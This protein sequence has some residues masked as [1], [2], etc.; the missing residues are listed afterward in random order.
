MKTANEM[1]QLINRYLDEMPYNRQPQQLYEPIRYILSLG[2]KRIRPT[3]MM[4]AYNLYQEDPERILPQACALETYHN[5]TLLH[6]DLMDHAD[7]RRG[8][9]FKPWP[10]GCGF[11]RSFAAQFNSK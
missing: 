1:L 2:G 10:L 9:N 11:F 7:M 8:S 3:L 5:F 6:D 4:L